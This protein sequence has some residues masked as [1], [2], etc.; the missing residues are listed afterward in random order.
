[1]TT[2]QPADIAVAPNDIRPRRAAAVA[3]SVGA[4]LAAAALAMHPRGVAESVE[5]VHHVEAAPDAWLTGHV[6]MTVGGILLALGLLAVPG[7]AR[8]RGRRAVAIG[9]WVAAIGA[10]ST[11]FGDFAHGALAYLLVGKVSAEESLH[12]QEHFYS[13]PL[14][15]G[16]SMPGLLLPVGMLVL[17]GALL[18]SRAV[19]PVAAVLVL[20][21][22]LAIQLG[23]MVLALPM[24]FMVLPLVAGLGWVSIALMK[25]P[26]Q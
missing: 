8:G 2:H 19:P 26:R 13:N 21:A 15:A 5:F 25:T 11:A 3:L 20:I 12:I 10:V 4:V 14:L 18:Y 1:M 17:G 16:V 9:S 6:L 22:P 23:Y 7:L 24:P